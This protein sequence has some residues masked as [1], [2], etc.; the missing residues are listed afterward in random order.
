[1][2][3][4]PEVE[5]I[6]SELEEK[7]KG[8]KI[9]GVDIRLP[10]IINL[11]VK[12]FKEIIKGKIIEK[13]GRRAKLIIIKLS[14]NWNLL[15]HLKLTGQLI[16]PHTYFRQ[17][18]L[19]SKNAKQS[20]VG[21]GVY[22][23]K[24]EK[25][26]HLIFYFND[27]SKLLFNDL[28][29][30]GYVKLLKDDEIEKIFIKSKLGPEPLDKSFTLKVLKDL[31]V[32]KQ[33]QKIKSLLMDQ[34]FISGLGNIYAQEI[35]FYAKVLPTRV[36]ATL[37][38]EEIK[39]IFNGIREVLLSAIKQK[40]SSIDNYRDIYGKKGNYVPFL[41]VYQRKGQKCFRCG[42]RVEEIKLGGRGTSFCPKCQK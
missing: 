40:G 31:L 41:K 15:I 2:P 4:L 34:T 16:Y 12:N 21:V 18:P 27:N 10:K 39:N 38:D 9:K 33:K 28:R 8:K 6:K 3:E 29:Q 35:C 26:T 17:K 5:T 30:F 24:E 37:K 1:M 25:Y 19:A 32:K 14:Q 20:K 13:I 23:G 7:I 11:P 42:G 22:N 36:V